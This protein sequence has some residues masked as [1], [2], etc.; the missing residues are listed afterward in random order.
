MHTRYHEAHPLEYD[1]QPSNTFLIA[2]GPGMLSAAAIALCPNVSMVPSITGDIA[3]VAFRFGLVVDQVCRSLEISPDEIN[4]AGAWIYCVYGVDPSKA[5]EAVALFNAEKV[6][7]ISMLFSIGRFSRLDQKLGV[8]VLSP[9][10][11]TQQSHSDQGSTDA[12]ISWDLHFG[13]LPCEGVI[14]V[15]RSVAISLPIIASIHTLLCLPFLAAYGSGV[16]PHI[17]SFCLYFLDLPWPS[18]L[19]I[20]S[21]KKICL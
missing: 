2:R 6:S 3:K 10:F 9:T 13:R 16:V 18:V 19:G 20:L 17:Q 14:L 1:F 21:Q 8:Q 12:S 15:A 11:R 5:Q 7:L 4:A